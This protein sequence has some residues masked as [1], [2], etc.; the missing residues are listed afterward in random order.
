VADPALLIRNY[1]AV[2]CTKRAPKGPYIASYVVGSD[3][4]TS[5]FDDYVAAVKAATNMPVVHIGDK[6]IRCAD[7]VIP[8]G[9][10][11]WLGLINSAK[12][13]ITNSFHATAFSL[14][15]EKKFIF[16]PHI[17][18]LLNDRQETLLKKVGLWNRRALSPTDAA[19]LTVAEIDYL[20]VRTKLDEF[21]ES[22]KSWLLDA[23]KST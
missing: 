9:P 22:S 15:F 19:G 13:V 11:E 7:Y 17:I 4:M 1:D 3:A 8:A 5:R 20:P 6:D 12:L 18:E 10:A 16:V 2:M 23:L 14:N 21:V